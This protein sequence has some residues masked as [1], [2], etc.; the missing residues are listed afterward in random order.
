MVRIVCQIDA[1]SKSHCQAL[2]WFYLRCE[3]LNDYKCCEGDA[4][5]LLFCWN[6]DI[7][8]LSPLQLKNFIRINCRIESKMLFRLEHQTGTF[9]AIPTSKDRLNISFR[10]V[11]EKYE[12]Y[13][14]NG[15]I[16]LQWGSTRYSITFWN[17]SHL[18]TFLCVNFDFYFTSINSVFPLSRIKCNETCGVFIFRHFIAASKLL[19]LTSS[20]SIHLSP[21]FS[22]CLVIFIPLKDDIKAVDMIFSH[23]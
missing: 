18:F 5:C 1:S 7:L 22:E 15:S 16:K 20:I 3:K 12:K 19:V 2:K 8:G 21:F 23:L 14:L 13:D 11:T 17:N 6:N 10:Y 4:S 9:S